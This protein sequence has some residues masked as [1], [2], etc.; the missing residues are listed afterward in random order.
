MI[1]GMKLGRAGR[2]E[3]VSFSWQTEHEDFLEAIN[4]Q[5]HCFG[6]RRDTPPEVLKELANRFADR[7]MEAVEEFYENYLEYKYGEDMGAILD[8][9]EQEGLIVCDDYEQ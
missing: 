3:K 8:Q 4:E 2:V 6:I 9:A 1:I 5:R 7:Q